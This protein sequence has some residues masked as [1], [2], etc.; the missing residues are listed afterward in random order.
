MIRC[1]GRRR[2][3]RARGRLHCEPL[4]FNVATSWI[5]IL[6]IGLSIV[7]LLWITVEVTAA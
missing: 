4:A 2:E 1:S 3:R 6:V 7:I 5:L